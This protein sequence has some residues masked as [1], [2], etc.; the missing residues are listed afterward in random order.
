MIY[1]KLP[2]R[3][4]Y[5][6]LRGYGEQNQL[7]AK[8]FIEDATEYR[9]KHLDVRVK[10]TLNIHSLYRGE[11]FVITE[12]HYRSKGEEIGL[13]LIDLL[14]GMVSLI[15]DNPV[16]PGTK[17]K[18]KIA[19]VLKLLKNDKLHPF[20][21]RLRL[22]QLNHSNQLVEVDFNY[23]IKL[24]INRNFNNYVRM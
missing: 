10:D 21:N 3:I 7:H 1:T 11:Y 2:E 6:L 15:L 9:S 20:I 13:E 17:K 4:F 19:L 14:L 22:F 8:I 16:A 24:F 5:G 23:S 12:C 18:A